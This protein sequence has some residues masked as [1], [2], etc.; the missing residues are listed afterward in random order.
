MLF[1]I[2]ISLTMINTTIGSILLIPAA[3]QL[4]GI[5]LD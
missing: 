3:I 1:G 4:T 2:L 5:E